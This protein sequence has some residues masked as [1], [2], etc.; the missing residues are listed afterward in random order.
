MNEPSEPVGTLWNDAQ[1]TAER[2][3][4]SSQG[5]RGRI[6]ELEHEV[7]ELKILNKGKD[8][9]VERLQ[10]EREAFANERREYVDHLIASNRKIGELETKLLQLEGI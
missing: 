9:F 5:D 2:T 1:R 7:L 3:G 8:Y 4:T 10:K 6:H